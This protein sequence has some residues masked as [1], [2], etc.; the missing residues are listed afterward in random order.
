MRT[1]YLGQFT[2]EVANEIAGELERASIW[3]H[4]KQA[5]GLTQIFFAGEWGTRLYVD[6]EK[7]EEARAIASRVH[8]RMRPDE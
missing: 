5:G 1:A 4:Y 3:W 6:E 8:R 2:D 7:L